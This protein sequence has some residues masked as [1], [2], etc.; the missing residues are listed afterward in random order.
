MVPETTCAAL[1][2]RRFRIAALDESRRQYVA[3]PALVQQVA[4]RPSAHRRARA[5]AAPRSMSIG[6]LRQVETRQSPRARPR[7]APPP[8]RGNARSL[9][10]APAGRRKQVLRRSSSFRGCRPPCRPRRSRDAA[11]I[12][13]EIAEAK[14]AAIMRRAH[15]QHRQRVGGKA[16]AAE[17]FRARHFRHAVEPDRRCADGLARCGQM[18]LSRQR[19]RAATPPS[20]PR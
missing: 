10:P 14:R 20:P 4:P 15:H 19:R 7:S 5:D 16:V 8:R 11:H 13:V 9:P 6:K 3:G 1:L 18:P 17:F 2:Q 12:G